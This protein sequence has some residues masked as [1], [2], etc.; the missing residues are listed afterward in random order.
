[1]FG[2]SLSKIL[3]TAGVALAVWYGFRVLGRLADRKSAGRGAPR[4]SG[5][6]GSGAA[7]R[8]GPD[9][10]SGSDIEDLRPCAVCGTFVAAGR[11]VACGRSDC[12]H[13]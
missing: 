12:P 3:L 1:V 9:R 6:A 8:P 13:R 2:L 11:A 4:D 5:A 10:A 7:D